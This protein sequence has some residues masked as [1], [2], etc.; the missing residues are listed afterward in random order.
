MTGRRLLF[1]P[2]GAGNGAFWDPIRSRLT[3]HETEAFDWPG[4]GE[5]PADPAV[6]SYADLVTMVTRRL[7][8]VGPSV[9]V[10]QS[11][12][13]WVAT[14]VAATR[15]ELVTHLVLC[16][17]SAGV[18]MQA[19]GAVDWRVGA[20]RA[21]PD[22]PEWSFEYHPPMED[23]LAELPHPTL[24]LWATADA[25]SPL[26]VGERVHDLIPDSTLVVYESSDHWVVLEQPDDVAARIRAH[27]A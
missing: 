18:D 24:L 12:G 2:G 20:R 5:T 25:I 8:T 23:R 1:L 3:D 17:T 21:R 6:T 26:A 7:E 11:M 15:P 14:S 13:G 22:A 16:V 19:L 10:G 27:V 4:L 9:L